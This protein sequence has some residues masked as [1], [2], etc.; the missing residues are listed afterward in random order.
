MSV[1]TLPFPL[2]STTRHLFRRSLSVGCKSSLPY[3][4]GMFQLGFLSHTPKV[5]WS[6]YWVDSQ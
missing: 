2:Q 1:A 3:G 6:G 5:R 4:V